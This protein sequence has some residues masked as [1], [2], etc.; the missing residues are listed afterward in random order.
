MR[1]LEVED[2][3]GGGTRCEGRCRRLLDDDGVGGSAFAFAAPFEGLL[4]LLEV[5]F[6]GGDLLRE[7]DDEPVVRAGVGPQRLVGGEEGLV[8]GFDAGD[9]ALQRFALFGRLL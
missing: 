2:G 7:G 8:G 1:P 6:E 3:D 4:G 9:V 5:G